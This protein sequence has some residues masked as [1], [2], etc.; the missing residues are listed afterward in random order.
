MKNNYFTNIIEAI[1]PIIKRMTSNKWGITFLA[2][3]FIAVI[4]D[5]ICESKAQGGITFLV[6]ILFWFRFDATKT[7]IFLESEGYKWTLHGIK[8]KE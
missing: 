8:K 2:I 7:T 3:L 1:S 5:W 6:F 4:I